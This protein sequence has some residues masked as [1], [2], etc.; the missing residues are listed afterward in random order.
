MRKK[1][2]LADKVNF[3]LQT[4]ELNAVTF[5]KPDGKM[6][7]QPITTAFLRTKSG[8][9]KTGKEIVK[10]IRAIQHDLGADNFRI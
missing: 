10:D 7:R 2:S 1:F 9:F 8:R 5:F 3:K 4:N 6:L